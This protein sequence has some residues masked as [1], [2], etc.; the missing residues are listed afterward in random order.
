MLRQIRITIGCDK[1]HGRVMSSDRE[2]TGCHLASK[3]VGVP[4]G[5]LIVQVPLRGL[6]PAGI[7]AY[8]VLQ[9]YRTP[10]FLLNA[11]LPLSL[12]HI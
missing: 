3:L 7:T 2:D 6:A 11:V 1:C 4:D 12:I 9:S 8:P 5:Y 10:H